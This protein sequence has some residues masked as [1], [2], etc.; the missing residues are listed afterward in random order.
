[1]K[2]VYKLRPVLPYKDKVSLLKDTTPCQCWDWNPQPLGQESGYL[3]T[4]LGSITQSG[5]IGQLD[6]IAKKRKTE[7]LFS[8]T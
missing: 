4:Q 7:S 3:L 6:D 8:L 2:K 5:R 1:M